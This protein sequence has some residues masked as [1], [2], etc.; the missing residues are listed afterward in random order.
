MKK[1]DN[2]SVLEIQKTK[3]L[4]VLKILWE[5][6]DDLAGNTKLT[7]DVRA[8]HSLSRSEIV[9]LLK[10]EHKGYNF[11]VKGVLNDLLIIGEYFDR[12]LRS[13]TCEIKLEEFVRTTGHKEIR[14]YIAKRP[15]SMVD[16]QMLLDATDRMRSI[17]SSKR[18]NIKEKLKW[19]A[20]NKI[21]TGSKTSMFSQEEFYEV[22]LETEANI[23]KIQSAMNKN[24]I[25]SFDY[26]SWIKK[27]GKAEKHYSASAAHMVSPWRMIYNNG[28][29]YLI[30]Y[31]PERDGIRTYRVDKMSNVCSYNLKRKGRDLFEAINVEDYHTKIFN[32]YSGTDREVRMHIYPGYEATMV[33]IMVDR[34][35]SGVKI[36]PSKD[37]G[38]DVVETISVSPHFRAWIISLGD[39]IEI[40]APES[41]REEMRKLIEKQ[42]KM[43]QKWCDCNAHK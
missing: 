7:E 36:I 39:G 19:L 30:A 14:Y 32:M 24:R 26:F 41:E 2:N 5:N 12:V 29:Y 40:T 35:G 28:Y 37:G 27:G 31:N 18:K 1:S 15:F 3:T 8:K 17:K 23:E 9:A 42:Q 38:L 11:N 13:K 34:F 16:I 21:W 25:I 22:D 6:T 4:S 43:Y 10:K 20:G 33:N